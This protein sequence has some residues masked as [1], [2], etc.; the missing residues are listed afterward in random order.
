MGDYTP[1]VGAPRALSYQAGA[2]IAAGQLVALD[3]AT[4]S[5]VPT[6]GAGVPYVGV[7]GNDAGPGDPAAVPP[8][9][10]AGLDVTVLSGSGVIHET[11]ATGT[12]AAGA[13]LQPGADG[14]VAGGGTNAN[15]IGVALTASDPAATPPVTM[16]RWQAFR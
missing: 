13:F 3:P 1:A 16:V 15:G 14:T 2:D 12:V 11:E 7:A 9:L 10:F 6:T 4:G 5:V 8:V